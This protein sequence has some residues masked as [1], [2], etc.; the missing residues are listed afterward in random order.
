MRSEPVLVLLAGL[1]GVINLGLVAASAT[2]LIKLDG[3]QIAAIVAFVT[4]AC[5][6]A[7]A[8][9]RARVTPA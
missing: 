2:G 5:A 7:A 3:N 1:A 6:L 4:S 8:V 9:I